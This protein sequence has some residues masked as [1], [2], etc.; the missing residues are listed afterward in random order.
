M[1]DSINRGLANSR[2]GVVILSKHFFDKHWPTQELNGLVTRESQG[3]KVILPI[4]HKVSKEQVARYSPIL[5]D[6]VAASTD[7]GLEYV[8]EQIMNVVRNG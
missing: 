8:V 2:Y 3:R 6:R 1:R 7:R 4:W 5:A